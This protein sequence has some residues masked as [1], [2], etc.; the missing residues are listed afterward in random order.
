MTDNKLTDAEIKK[1]LECCSGGLTS[2]WCD[3]C[4]MNATKE[5]D[6]DLLAL[7]KL[8]LDLINRLQAE[9]E[10]LINGQE[11]L[12]KY[13][14]TLQA[15]NE[16]FSEAIYQGTLTTATQLRA[17]ENRFRKQVEQNKRITAEAR[18]EFAELVKGK[19]SAGEDVL[20]LQT[21][22]HFVIDNLLIEMESEENGN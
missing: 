19:F 16:M 11:T 10:A 1:A 15:E 9:N 20:Y 22:I 17:E 14:A 7:E 6:K 18:K 8:A 13:I 12:Q 4:P 2:D 3:K 5:C 21:L